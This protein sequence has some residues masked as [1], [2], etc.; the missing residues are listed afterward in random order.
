MEDSTQKSYKMLVFGERIGDLIMGSSAAELAQE[1]DEPEDI[2][3]AMNDR[4]ALGL[5]GT[6]NIRVKVD[7]YSVQ[8]YEV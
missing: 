4:L 2:D 1:C 5:H 3:R 6:F 8:N 7:A